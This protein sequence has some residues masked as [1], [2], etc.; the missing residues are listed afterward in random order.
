MRELNNYDKSR[1]FAWWLKKNLNQ[2]SRSQCILKSSHLPPR[3]PSSPV[4]YRSCRRWFA[5]ASHHANQS[6]S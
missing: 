2:S 6:Q 4:I 5:S 3:L 1:L